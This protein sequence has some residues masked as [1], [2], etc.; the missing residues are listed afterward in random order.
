MHVTQQDRGAYLFAENEEGH[1]FPEPTADVQTIADI[2][3]A[4]TSITLNDDCSTTAE[5]MLSLARLIAAGDWHAMGLRDDGTVVAIAGNTS[6]HC[7]VAGR[8]LK[9]AFS[10]TAARMNTLTSFLFSLTS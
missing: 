4:T 1:R 5:S 8:M 9:S 2:G 3:P 7:H 10:H 6:G